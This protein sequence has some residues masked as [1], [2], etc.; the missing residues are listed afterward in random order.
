MYREPNV[1]DFNEWCD[2]LAA[3]YP[4]IDSQLPKQIFVNGTIGAFQ[5]GKMSDDDYDLYQRILKK[6]LSE[7]K[8][9]PPYR[10]DIAVFLPETKSARLI[11]TDSISNVTPLTG[12]TCR[13]EYKDE[14][15]EP[16]FAVV[17]E[18]AKA[19]RKRTLIKG[20]QK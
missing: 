13:I 18:S 3:N 8:I 16:N 6:W 19:I 17:N 10:D 7:K 2:Y 9:I 12:D 4:E 1:N 15:G 14:N 5:P 20:L 11:Y